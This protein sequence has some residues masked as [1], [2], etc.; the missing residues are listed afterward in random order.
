M[1]VNG[2]SDLARLQ[3]LQKRMVAARDGMDRAGME[4]TTGQKANRFEATG[5]NL[6]RL[7]SLER[8]LERNTIH[9]QT[10]S[11]TELRLDLTQ[12]SL[13]RILKSVEDLSLGL[14]TSVGSGDMIS[15]RVHA[16]TARSAFAETIGVLNGSA[17]G[18]SLFAGTRSDSAAVAD[19]D[20][21]LGDLNALVGGSATAADAISAINDYFRRDPAPAGAFFTNGYKGSTDDLTAVEVGDG[22][23]VEQNVRADR[24]EIVA[25]L[26]SQAMAAVV[27]EGAFAGNPPE[28]LAMLGE[29]GKQ[30]LA[31]KED[32]LALRA[33][34]G[35]AQYRVE[36]ARAERVSERD[37]LDLARARIVATDPLEAA[38]A[39]QSLQSQLESVFTV[40]SRLANLRFSNF[41]R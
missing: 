34:V 2:A 11:A 16:S 37:T 1:N 8:S 4:M 39:F 6:T 13:G 38:T 3:N 23:R 26:R 27:A 29:A 28:Q 41:I 15:A 33:Q 18:Q 17:A 10:I 30:M 40:T 7:F 35:A 31:A 21:I 9:Q 12:V 24:R 14:S 36:S 25:V 32:V 19:A 22:Q 5:G 20:L